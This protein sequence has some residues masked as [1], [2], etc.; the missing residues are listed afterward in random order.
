MVTYACTQ[1]ALVNFY[2]PGLVESQICQLT[3]HQGIASSV[4]HDTQLRLSPVEQHHSGMENGPG[5]STSDS[6]PRTSRYN[7]LKMNLS[8]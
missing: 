1:D 6:K 3:A 8:T 2:I 4:S 5:N 7:I